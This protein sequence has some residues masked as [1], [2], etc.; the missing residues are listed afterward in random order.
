MNPVEF[1]VGL[2]ITSHMHARRFCVPRAQ[3]CDAKK[4]KSQRGCAAI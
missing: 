3:S 1:V 4:W 2:V